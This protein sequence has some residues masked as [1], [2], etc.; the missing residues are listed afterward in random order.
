MNHKSEDLLVKLFE[1]KNSSKEITLILE[2]EQKVTITYEQLW[3]RSGYVASKLRE[4][5]AKKGS[6]VL[7]RCDNLENYLYAFWGCVQNQSIAIPIDSADRKNG[8]K[9][10]Q[11]VMLDV[12]IQKLKQQ[13]FES[14]QNYV[15]G[16]TDSFHSDDMMVKSIENDLVTLQETI[17]EMEVAYIK[18]ECD[19]DALSVGSEFAVLSKEMI[20]HYIEK[21][22]VYD[23]QHIEICW[24]EKDRAA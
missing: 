2:N 16:K 6:E 13:N 3:I 15:S 20:D 7:I 10:M 17:Q 18:M 4:R 14:Y 12:R 19:R 24:K 5:G 9:I 23:E 11:L 1:M 22:V 8:N 21:I